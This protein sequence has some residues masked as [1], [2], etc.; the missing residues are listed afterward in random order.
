MFPTHVSPHI[1]KETNDTSP[2]SLD[3]ARSR[4][5]FKAIGAS[6]APDDE[7]MNTTKALPTS[8]KT[9]VLTKS[10][11]N[12]KGINIV[13]TGA[14]IENPSVGTHTNAAI[15]ENLV[16]VGGPTGGE[17]QATQ[18][19]IP[20]KVLG[21]RGRFVNE[22]VVVR[23]A[24]PDF[25]EDVVN[26][27]DG[28]MEGEGVTEPHEDLDGDLDDST[29]HEKENI[30]SLNGIEGAQREINLLWTICMELNVAYDDLKASSDTMGSKRTEMAGHT[31]YSTRRNPVKQAN[32][33]G[34]PGF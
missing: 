7:P 29:L 17:N 1:S 30:E 16:M 4:V 14:F 20:R 9:D 10:S 24:T 26:G 13:D 12:G 33:R 21:K 11:I 3:L 22:P 34:K 28:T 8:L 31:P 27:K 19:D 18:I 6:T 25:W 5:F 2:I 15:N 23:P 32:R